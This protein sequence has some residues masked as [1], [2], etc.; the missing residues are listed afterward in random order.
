M[1]QAIFRALFQDQFEFLQKIRQ[2]FFD[3]LD[4]MS[5]NLHLSIISMISSLV[6]VRFRSK[7]EI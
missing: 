7:G 6:E 2:V 5:H 4:Y 1:F 3:L